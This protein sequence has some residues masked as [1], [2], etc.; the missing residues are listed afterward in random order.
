M[1]PTVNYRPPKPWKGWGQGYKKY[2]WNRNWAELWLV[3]QILYTVWGK[4]QPLKR[5][6]TLLDFGPCLEIHRIVGKSS[7]CPVWVFSMLPNPP[8]CHIQQKSRN[9]HFPYKIKKSLRAPPRL[10]SQLP[11]WC[12][13][14]SK[15][16]L[17]TLVNAE[18]QNI[19][20]LMWIGGKFW[21]NC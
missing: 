1:R 12:T 11:C 5:M 18:N 19:T 14:F 4:I 21:D 6:L 2:P 15:S 8:K 7:A 13:I 10:P 17:P 9:Q 3:N 20:L 16:P